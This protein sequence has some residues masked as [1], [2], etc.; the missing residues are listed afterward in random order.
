MR[1]PHDASKVARVDIQRGIVA[2]P[3]GSVPRSPGHVSGDEGNQLGAQGM[4]NGLNPGIPGKEGTRDGLS[5]PAEYSLK[6]KP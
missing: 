4:R 6:R 3:L 2:M 5:F 1:S